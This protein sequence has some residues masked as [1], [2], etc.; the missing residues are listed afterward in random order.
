LSS[1]LSQNPMNYGTAC[2]ND[3]PICRQK[4]EEI[5]RR[6]SATILSGEKAKCGT[7]RT[8]PAILIL[9]WHQKLSLDPFSHNMIVAHSF[10][11]VIPPDLGNRSASVLSDGLDTGARNP[12]QVLGCESN[13]ESIPPQACRLIFEICELRRSFSR[14]AWMRAVVT[15]QL[16]R[17]KKK[18]RG[19]FLG[20]GH[21]ADDQCSK[22]AF[23]R[24][25]QQTERLTRRPPFRRNH[26]RCRSAR[27]T[28]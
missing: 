20:R 12:K 27:D 2:F 15:I 4:R 18:T 3:N 9:S 7:L 8:K 16:G 11:G 26:K 5:D 19:V 21:E 13:N 24:F 1:Q 25:T 14:L 23:A 22:P 28:A 17:M 10:L 6:M